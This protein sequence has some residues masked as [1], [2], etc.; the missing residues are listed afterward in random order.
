[1]DR[2]E[3]YG[4]PK[5]VVSFVVPSGLSLN[6]DGSSLYL[7][8]S[9]IFLAQAFHVEMPLSQQLLMML[10]LVMTSKGIA[11]VP[12]GSLVVLLA[13]ANAVGLPAEGVAII[14]GVDRVMDMART[15]VN[16]PG[17]AVACIVVSKWEKLSNI[18]DLSRQTRPHGQKVCNTKRPPHWWSFLLINRPMILFFN[19]SKAF[20]D[21]F[22]SHF[23][24]FHIH[25]AFVRTAFVT[26]AAHVFVFILRCADHF[27]L[28]AGFAQ[29]T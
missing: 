22:L 9:C 7:S 10:V 21:F 17:H 29:F 3:K 23:V 6:C 15:G 5:R 18:K 12:S 2:M 24:L 26:A 4:C 8:V 1:M 20:I 11:A 28:H 19:Q 25:V 27:L 13:T 14:A 16:V